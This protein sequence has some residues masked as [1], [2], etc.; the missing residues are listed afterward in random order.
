MC[1][2]DNVPCFHDRA[3]TLKRG[4]VGVLCSSWQAL[5]LCLE[6]QTCAW[7]T[8][9]GCRV[10]VWRI[11]AF[12]LDFMWHGKHIQTDKGYIYDGILKVSQIAKV[13][14]TSSLLLEHGGGGNR[15]VWKGEMNFLRK[16]NKLLKH[17]FFPTVTFLRKEMNKRTSLLANE[18]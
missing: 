1:V 5:L 4:K 16:A 15:W 17:F 3:F 9:K 7:E 14:V 13:V 12:I 6:G 2:T 10:W 18:N 11:L 8:L